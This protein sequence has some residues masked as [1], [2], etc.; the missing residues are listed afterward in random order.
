VEVT[1]LAWHLVEYSEL[2]DEVVG[3]M[4]RVQTDVCKV[5]CEV[6]CETPITH[7]NF[8]DNITAPVI[9]EKYFRKYAAKAYQQLAG[10]LDETGKNVPVQVHMDGDLKVLARAIA[11]SGVRSLDSMSPPPDND[12]S[13]ADAIAF[14]PNVSICI[15]FPSSVH[16]L[17]PDDIYKAAMEIC[18]QG[19]RLGRLQIQISENV[20][21]G[22]WRKSY[23][24]I[25]KATVDFGAASS[26][27]G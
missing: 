19:Q 16:L 27:M 13:V 12:T 18:E 2:M 20:P 3:E 22:V 17:P 5:A 26:A 24:Q 21:P 7:I 25:A 23:P 8:G 10:M 15:N 11:E 6:A 4:E 1:D 9:G 14:W